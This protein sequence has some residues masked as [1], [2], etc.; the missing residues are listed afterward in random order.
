MYHELNLLSMFTG[1]L[2][3][4]HLV[5]ES[6][7]LRSFIFLIDL[8]NLFLQIEIQSSYILVACQGKF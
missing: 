4:D 1:V 3:Y 5:H 8:M 7:L 6:Y 2:Q